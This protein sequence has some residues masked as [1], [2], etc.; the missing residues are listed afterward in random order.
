[1][2]RSSTNTMKTF[3]EKESKI[4]STILTYEPRW[5]YRFG[6]YF[7][8][9]TPATETYC[10][11]VYILDGRNLY[12]IIRRDEGVVRCRYEL[13]DSDHSKL[14]RMVLLGGLQDGKEES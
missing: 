1:M 3:K 13:N 12:Q 9:V 8:A 11:C 6:R 14:M 5:R 10:Q 7:T 2:G 4:D